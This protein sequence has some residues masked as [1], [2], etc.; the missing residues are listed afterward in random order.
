MIAF[1][2]W[3]IDDLNTSLN[4][5]TC[6]VLNHIT[7]ICVSHHTS[8]TCVYIYDSR[9]IKKQALHATSSNPIKDD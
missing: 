6:L 4:P 9:A 7:T 3:D 5:H 1:V 8:Y 2:G